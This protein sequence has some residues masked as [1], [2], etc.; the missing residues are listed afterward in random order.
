MDPK[1]YKPGAKAEAP[2]EQTSSQSQEPNS[3]KRVEDDGKKAAA[4]TKQQE[5]LAKS[6]AE[7]LV[8]DPKPVESVRLE[9][10]I[11]HDITADHDYVQVQHDLFCRDCGH[12]GDW[13]GRTSTYQ[14]AFRNL[15]KRVVI[16][17]RKADGNG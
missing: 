6:K 11:K 13:H 7:K 4:S 1:S 10:A 14:A 8:V 2:K 9:Q 12:I 5:P 15:L 3:D 17:T 16:D